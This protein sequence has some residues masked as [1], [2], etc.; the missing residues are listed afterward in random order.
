MSIREKLLKH[1]SGKYGLSAMRTTRLN[2]FPETSGND[3]TPTSDT[4]GVRIT[5]IGVTLILDAHSR[6]PEHTC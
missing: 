2:H 4:Q 5:F 3:L 1:K 6:V